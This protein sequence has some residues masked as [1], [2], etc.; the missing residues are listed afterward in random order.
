MRKAKRKQILY[1]RSLKGLVLGL[2]LFTLAVST[3][4]A[5][6]KRAFGVKMA[7]PHALKGE[8]FLIPKGTQHL[9]SIRWE[10]P[11]G[12]IYTEEL[13]IPKRDFR[14]GFPGITDR[15]EWFAIRYAGSFRVMEEGKYRFKLRSDDGSRL[16]IDNR[17]V[18]DNDGAHAAHT[19]S[20]SIRLSRG[21]H[22][23]RVEYFQG[24]R[25]SVALQLW[26][27]PPGGRSIIFRMDK[28]VGRGDCPFGN[29]WQQ[30][31]RSLTGTIYEVSRGY[32]LRPG[33]SRGGRILGTVYTKKLDVRPGHF[34]RGFPFITERHNWF[35][36]RYTGR[37]SVPE[38]G[39]YV[40]SVLADDGAILYVDGQM[41]VD[42]G[43]MHAPHTRSGRIHLYTGSHDIRV[44]YFQATDR[45]ALQLFITPPNRNSMAFVP[46]RLVLPA[47]PPPP[48]TPAPTPV[49]STIVSTQ[50]VSSDVAVLREKQG[51]VDF[52]SQGETFQGDGFPDSHIEMD[53]PNP[54]S[55]QW[56]SV[57]N[58]DGFP[59][60]WDTIPGNK[61]WALAVTMDGLRQNRPDGS[62]HFSTTRPH[63]HL[64]LYMQDNGSISA[65]LTHYTV[66]I[67]LADGT[68]L[69]YPVS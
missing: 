16:Y 63:C 9:R 18:V 14:E 7:I 36:I 43:G 67:G 8:I 50:P 31:G 57:E 42:N 25:F 55:I 51:L 5:G 33:R 10:N 22:S 40:F 60:R 3:T 64:N 46:G 1:L 44:D 39:D 69:T 34:D 47:L 6:E 62:I 19:R 13:D 37:F 20:G 45:V 48:V 58:S 32:T 28:P 41:V 17:K 23:I 53:I 15:F 52:V 68:V 61:G 38:A 11:V 59:S 26:I 30:S 2:M 65:G 49:P 21:K 29:V 24:P 54:S 27:L 4:W 56:I 12:T 35:M 66:S